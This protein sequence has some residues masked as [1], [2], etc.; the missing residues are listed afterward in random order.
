MRSPNERDPEL[1]RPVASLSRTPPGKTGSRPVAGIDTQGRKEL[2]SSA[3]DSATY[4]QSFAR[5]LSVIEAFEGSEHGLTLAEVARRTG[6]TRASARRSLLTLVE[7]GYAR[8][9]GPRFVLGPRVL[10]LGF[11]YLR[12]QGLWATAQSPMVELVESIHESCSAAVLDGLEIVYV[13]RVPTRSRIMSISLGVG[14]R[15]PA[16]ATSMGRVLLAGLPASERRNALSRLKR[17]ERHTAQTIT[18]LGVLA[19][20]LDQIERQGFAIVDQE[21]EPGLRSLAVPLFDPDRRTIAALNVGTHAAR[22]TIERLR[23]EILPELRQ[24]ARRIAAAMPAAPR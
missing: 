2:V 6:L 21:L 8:L 10:K 9:D 7:L 5:G 3:P 12:S 13:A 23:R 24:C 11:S 14:S 18:D 4:V 19:N 15:L 17:L 22:V 20:E 1:N 16:A